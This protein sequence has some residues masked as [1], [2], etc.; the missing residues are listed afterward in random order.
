M[1]AGDDNKKTLCVLISCMNQDS[2]IIQRSNVQTDVVVI[3]QCDEERYLEFDFSNKQGKNC[4]AKFISTTERGLSRS[5][6][7]AI[8][9][10]DSDICLI[11]DDDE[12]LA[13]SYEEYI[14]TAYNNLPQAGIITF[15][16]HR[17]DKPAFFS[18]KQSAIGFKDI[19]RTASIQITFKLSLISEH[20]IFFDEKMGSGTGNGGGEENKFL[21][22]YYKKGVKM[23]YVPDYITTLDNN[24]SLWRN[25]FTEEYFRNWG[26][27]SRRI[28]G[29]WLGLAYV[30]TIRHHSSYSSEASFFKA[31]KNLTRGFF[32]NR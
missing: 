13:D 4:H 14:L 24:E 12:V 11:C 20:T 26:W 27:S 19:M 32:E 23:Y 16:F 17:I 9:N 1:N 31:F 6:N 8:R 25:G 21:Y 5:R 28:M 22:D 18:N 2:S 10:C 3:N 29:T 30:V 15:P 7:M